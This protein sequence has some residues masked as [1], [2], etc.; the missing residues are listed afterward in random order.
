MT[1]TH[2]CIILCRNPG[3]GRLT[4][5]MDDSDRVDTHKIMEFATEDDAE[6]AAE[7]MLMLKVWPW[8]IVRISL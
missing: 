8:E 3:S 6:E 2:P 1:K 7:K 5:V 4:A